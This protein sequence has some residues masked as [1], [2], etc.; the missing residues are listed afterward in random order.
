MLT[1]CSVRSIF[2]LSVGV[3]GCAGCKLIPRVQHACRNVCDR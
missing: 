2:G 3:S 1:D